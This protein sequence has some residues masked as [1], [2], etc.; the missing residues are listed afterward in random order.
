MTIRPPTHTLSRPSDAATSRLMDSHSGE[1]SGV[2]VT[3]QGGEMGNH[4]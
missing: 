1:I 3:E 2:I 4:G